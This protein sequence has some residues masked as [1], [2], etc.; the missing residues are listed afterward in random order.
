[1]Q[2]FPG[3]IRLESGQSISEPLSEEELELVSDPERLNRWG[4][5]ANEITARQSAKG[6][7]YFR[8]HHLDNGPSRTFFVTRVHPGI[9][10]TDFS[11]KVPVGTELSQLIR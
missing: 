11:I 5:G 10:P 7:G 9:S 8:I 2:F 6:P 4:L 1:M 3:L